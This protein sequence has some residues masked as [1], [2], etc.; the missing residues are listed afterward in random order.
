MSR[1]LFQFV[2]NLQ[3]RWKMLVV[4]L[5]LVVL[6]IFLIGALVG[7]IATSQATRGITAASQADL[8][9][10]ARFTLDLLDS[11]CQMAK[12]E[13]VMLSINSDAHSFLEFENLRY[14][15]S[16]TG[17]STRSARSDRRNVP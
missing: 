12:E 7:T 8:D 15:R 17:R 6:P 13:G 11:H 10:L 9:H 4:V 5:P 3:I 1:H 16:H 14:G 2:N